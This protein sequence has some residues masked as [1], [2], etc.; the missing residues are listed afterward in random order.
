MLTR[1]VTI[2]ITSKIVGWY[3]ARSYP[4]DSQNNNDEI[5]LY[6]V[7]SYEMIV[8]GTDESGKSLTFTHQ[9]PRFMPYWNN[10]SNPDKHYK[11]KGWVNSGLS[12]AQTIV[13]SR[14]LKDYE[15]HNRYSPAHGAIVL[16]NTFYIHAGPVDENDY[17]FGSAGCV[18]NIGDFGALKSHI[19]LLSG[20]K[21]GNA[22]DAIQTLVKEKHLTAVIQAAAV[23]DIRKN[24]TRKIQRA[25][26]K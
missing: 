25:T 14:Y 11:T 26:W 10:P 9:A 22:D 19:A 8:S 7:P 17:G 16:K 20:F 1:K 5:E 18:E 12:S 15:L 13:V 4:Q 24:Y 3:E 6:K 21:G 2:T 23:P